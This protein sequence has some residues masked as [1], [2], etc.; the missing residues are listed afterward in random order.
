MHA[1]ARPRVADGHT[2]DVLTGVPNFPEGE[3]YDGYEHRLTEEDRERASTYV[4]QRKRSSSKDEVDSLDERLDILNMTV[5]VGSFNDADRVRVVQ[6][7]NKTNQMN[8]RTQWRSEA[9]FINWLDD[10][11]RRLRTFRVLG[12]LGNS[13]LT[14]IFLTEKNGEDAHF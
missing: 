10:E 12:R 11:E 3:V 4:A 2:V 13:R 7:L 1:H 14:G 6:L 8:L 5:Q 9:G